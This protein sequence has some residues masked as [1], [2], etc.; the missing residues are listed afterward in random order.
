MQRNFDEKLKNSI[1][2]FKK[3]LMLSL[4]C[5]IQHCCV[6]LANQPPHQAVTLPGGTAFY[7]LTCQHNAEYLQSTKLYRHKNITRSS[8]H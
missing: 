6:V 1:E 5:G 8:N 2:N 3:L 4:T 7:N